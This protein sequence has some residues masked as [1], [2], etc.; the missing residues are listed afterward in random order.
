M[1]YGFKKMV[2]TRLG[3]IRSIFQQIN[4]NGDGDENYGNSCQSVKEKVQVNLESFR[5]LSIRFVLDFLH[6]DLSIFEHRLKK[7][8]KTGFLMDPFPVMNH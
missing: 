5:W 4:G 6:V 1:A 7:A 3:Q 2:A 8:G